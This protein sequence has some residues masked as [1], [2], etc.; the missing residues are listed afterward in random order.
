MAEFFTSDLSLWGLFIS[1]CLAATLLPGGS[2]A[3]LFGVL[4]A[5]PERCGL[6]CSSPASATRWAAW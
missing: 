6:R 3:V 4:K 2:E 1:S 5:Y